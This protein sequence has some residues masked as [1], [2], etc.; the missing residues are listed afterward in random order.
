[1]SQGR[2][3]LRQR[4]PIHP[5]VRLPLGDYLPIANQ[6]PT[7]HNVQSEPSREH[8]IGRLAP[9]RENERLS[10]TPNPWETAAQD[11]GGSRG[12]LR[13][14]RRLIDGGAT[15]AE[16]I[17]YLVGGLIVDGGQELLATEV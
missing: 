5:R 7:S 13:E 3:E 17:T 11:S 10:S 14:L 4:P 9:T 8:P 2:P 16:I 1:M 12:A 15:P 6:L